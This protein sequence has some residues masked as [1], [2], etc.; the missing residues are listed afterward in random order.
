MK[1]ALSLLALAFLTFAVPH[2]F[3]QDA[4]TADPS[5]PACMAVDDAKKALTANGEKFVEIS[6][7]SLLG[8]DETPATGILVSTLQGAVVVGIEVG[9]GVGNDCIFSL[10]PI[11]TIKAAVGG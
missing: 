5:K 11:G 3:A 8:V 2:A 7:Q 1:L 4:P 10:H 6:I 9:D